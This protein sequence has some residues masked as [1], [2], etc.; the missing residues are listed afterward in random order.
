MDSIEM[1]MARK[2]GTVCTIGVIIAPSA[3]LKE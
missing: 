2:G 3:I 1:D